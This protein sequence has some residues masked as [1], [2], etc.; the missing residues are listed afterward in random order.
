MEQSV[1][2]VHPDWQKENNGR[3]SHQ[4]VLDGV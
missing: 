2:M 1:R 3:F 4:E